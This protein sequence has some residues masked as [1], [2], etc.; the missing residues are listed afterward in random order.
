MNQPV[1]RTRRELFGE[2]ISP[3][4]VISTAFVFKQI[5]LDALEMISFS[6]DNPTEEFERLDKA[7]SK[8]REQIITITER[9]ILEKRNAAI[10]DIFNA[11]LHL[12]NETTFIQELKSLVRAQKMN[13]EHVVA[14]Q[15]RALE[16]RFS[17]IHDELIRSKFLDVQDVYHRI[18]RNLLEIEH[19]RTNPMQRVE[20]PVIFVSER[21]VPSDV[22]LLDFKKIL[23][24]IIEEGS[25]VS[26]VAVISKSL[27]IPTIIN[28]PGAGSLIH[29]SDSVIIDGYTGKIIVNPSHSEIFAFKE[30]SEHLTHSTSKR[31]PRIGRYCETRDGRRVRLEAN[32]G[33]VREAEIAMAYGAEGI[34]LLRSELFY[35]SCS[36]MPCID[37]EVEFYRKI[38]AVTKRKP[39]TIRLLDLGADK[40]LP[41]LHSFAEENPQLGHRGIRYLFRHPEILKQHLESILTVCRLTHIKIALP[42]VTTI[43]DLDKAIGFIKEGCNNL[44]INF[45][46]LHIGI[47]VEIPSV[48]LSMRSFLPKVDFVNI[49]TND[50]IQYIFAA[51]REDSYLEEYRQSSHPANIRIIRNIISAANYRNKD[52]SVCGEMASDV[53]MAALLIGSGTTQLSMQPSSIPTIRQFIMKQSFSELQKLVRRVLPLDSAKDVQGHLDSFLNHQSLPSERAA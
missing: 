51:S 6:I 7:I 16:G 40:T 31:T 20:S 44:K 53:G 2:P 37:E 34:G 14:S 28:V 43:E 36:K 17:A 45:E 22:A 19:V 15:I 42:F 32:I 5:A 30:K 29:Q 33:S 39:I 18:L 4:V 41:Y 8:S 9:L 46:A 21:L 24:I 25:K 12:L 49:G 26:H 27:E 23:G 11:Q 35:M 50:L 52:A 48:A 38:I 3:G 10:Q 1:E 13:I 47:M